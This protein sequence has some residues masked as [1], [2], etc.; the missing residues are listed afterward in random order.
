MAGSNF[1]AAM[2]APLQSGAFVRPRGFG[3]W[4]EVPSLP[5]GAVFGRLILARRESSCGNR[6]F[7]GTGKL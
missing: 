4:R 3:D 7:D 6:A 2:R 5:A 1:T